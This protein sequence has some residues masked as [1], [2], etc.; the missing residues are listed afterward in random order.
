MGA[1]NR[2]PP[3]AQ[4]ADDN[5]VA[6]GQASFLENTHGDRDLMLAGEPTQSLY[7]CTQT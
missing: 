5:F 2:D 1:V 7:D 4:G 6:R 3:V